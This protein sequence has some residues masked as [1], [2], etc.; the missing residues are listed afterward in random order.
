MYVK[1]AIR[2][3]KVRAYFA[4]CKPQ[5]SSPRLSIL[6]NTKPSLTVSTLRNN[7]LLSC[8]KFLANIF[9]KVTSFPWINRRYNLHI[10]DTEF[11]NNLQGKFTILDVHLDPFLCTIPSITF[12]KVLCTLSPPKIH[13]TIIYLSCN[14][15]NQNGI[16][17]T[18]CP[19]AFSAPK[20]HE[21][22]L[23]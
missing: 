11:A 5:T 21:F 3:P 20:Y 18:K 15:V 22:S 9:S 23:P 2:H 10:Y 19:I 7:L 4:P 16:A 17:L 1:N 8:A 13:Q 12:G 14:H 6:E